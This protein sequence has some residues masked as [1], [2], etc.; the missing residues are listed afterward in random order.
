MSHRFAD[1]NMVEGTG[2]EGP[3]A[4]RPL[5][6]ERLGLTPFKVSTFM[7]RCHK[8]KGPAFVAEPGSPLDLQPSGTPST[9][10]SY[11]DAAEQIGRNVAY[12]AYLHSIGRISGD[13][14]KK[15]VSSSSLTAYIES[16]KLNSQPR[17]VR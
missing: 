10:I 3:L 14:H 9:R 5:I 7:S 6:M 4:C 2:H 12:I 15:T 8:Y 17:R 16:K 13:K 1:E 11:E